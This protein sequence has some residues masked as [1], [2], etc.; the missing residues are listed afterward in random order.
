MQRL[1]VGALAAVI[2]LA[3]GFLL[4]TRL[5]PEEDVRAA[6]TRSLQRAT[7]VEPRISGSAKD[8]KSV[9]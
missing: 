6:V 5:V 9:V 4:M 8:R 2:L 7:G 3:G 1:I